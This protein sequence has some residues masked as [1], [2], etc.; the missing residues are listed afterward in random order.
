MI[1]SAVVVAAP[2]AGLAPKN[3]QNSTHT[4]GI[5]KFFTHPRYRLMDKVEPFTY[6]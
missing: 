2:C 3:I 5:I 6:T 1:A 4:N